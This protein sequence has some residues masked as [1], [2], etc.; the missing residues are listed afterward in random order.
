LGRGSDNVEYE[1]AR[2]RVLTATS[3]LEELDELR[4]E[5]LVSRVAYQR[6]RDWYSDRLEKA[7]A[8]AGDHAGDSELDKQLVESLRR[9]SAIERETVRRAKGAGLITNHSAATLQSEIVKR[10][11]ALEA[12]S[13]ESEERVRAHLDM[14]LDTSGDDDDDD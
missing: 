5:G 12:A 1:E 10:V 7:Q 4:D 2:A 9:L 14:L 8:E 13:G 3:G 11:R 6:V